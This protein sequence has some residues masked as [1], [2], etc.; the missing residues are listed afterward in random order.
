MTTETKTTESILD[1]TTA[2]VNMDG[3]A[4]LL[5]EIV[6]IFMETAGDQFASLEAAI[7]AGDVSLTAIQAHALKGGASNFCA[8]RFVAAALRLELHAKGGSLDGAEQMV[9][10]MRTRLDEVREVVAAVNWD[11][12]ARNWQG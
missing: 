10:D 4:E 11:E 5:Q 1:L 12:I 9:T 3:D 6:E 8:G 2:M 7:A